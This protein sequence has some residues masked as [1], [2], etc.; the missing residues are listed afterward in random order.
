MGY[1]DRLKRMKK[2]EPKYIINKDADDFESMIMLKFTMKDG[3]VRNMTV[4]EAMNEGLI[5]DYKL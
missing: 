4:Q 3:T 2:K 1:K 5:I